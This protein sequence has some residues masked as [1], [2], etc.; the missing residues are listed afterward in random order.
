LSTRIKSYLWF[1]LYT[2][3]KL[4]ASKTGIK[5]STTQLAKEI[6][7]SQQSASRHLKILEEMKLIKRELDVEGSRVRITNKGLGALEAVLDE[8]RWHLDEEESEIITLEGV[9]ESGLFQGAYYISKEGYTR[10]IEE[11]LG[12]KP[13]PGTLNLRINYEGMENRKRI[14]RRNGAVLEGFID[15]DRA[16][17]AAR[18]YN[19]IIEGKVEGAL[20]IAERT[21]H[22]ENVLEIISPV[23]LRRELGLVDGDRVTI[24]FLPLRRFVS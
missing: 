10:Q 1:T 14:E 9:V 5:I 11:K 3:L 23:Y 13:F 15:E 19:L 24:E 17:G 7:G 12:F 20:I 4:G 22:D 2:L 21:L 16:Y 8:L 18:C 6:E